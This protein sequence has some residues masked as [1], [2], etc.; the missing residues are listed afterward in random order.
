MTLE[1]GRTQKTPQRV[2]I[3]ADIRSQL[4]GSDDW[5]VTEIVQTREGLREQAVQ[6]ALGIIRDASTGTMVR[7][8]NS[9]VQ[10]RFRIHVL[11]TKALKLS[12][13]EW[14][15]RA[16]NDVRPGDVARF[17]IKTKTHYNGRPITQAAKSEMQ[18]R[19][20]DLIEYFEAKLDSDCCCEVNFE[21]AYNALKHHGK[22]MI[23]PEFDRLR[24]DEKDA[25]GKL[26]RK[27]SNW[28]FEEVPAD[29]HAPNKGQP[30]RK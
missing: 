7:E 23:H 21:L 25:H 6:A 11:C 2:D 13:D 28:H 5:T 18:A 3:E 16:W 29:W 27:I 12:K 17:K 1:L 10:R 19:G 15:E 8:P 4:F 20:I 22:N 24:A 9:G 14:E 26:V 30:T